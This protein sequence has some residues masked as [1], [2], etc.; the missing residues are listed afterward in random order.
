[1][2]LSETPEGKSIAAGG[3]SSYVYGGT[4]GRTVYIEAVPS[5]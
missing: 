5:G 2:D 1:V 3:G 4:A